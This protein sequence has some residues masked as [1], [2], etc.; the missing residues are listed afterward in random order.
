M[1]KRFALRV[2][3]G[4][5]SRDCELIGKEFNGNGTIEIRIER[6][7]DHAHAAG[8][9]RRLQFVHTEPP[10]GQQGSRQ[11]AHHLRRQCDG[12]AVK[13]AVAKRG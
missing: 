4:A 9:Y 1:T 2:G 12:W 3:T 7:I 5:A 8:A 13:Q 10:A 6:P 11:L